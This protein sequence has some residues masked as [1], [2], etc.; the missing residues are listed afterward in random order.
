[1]DH[2]V[3]YLLLSTLLVLGRV[4]CDIIVVDTDAITE[5]AVVLNQDPIDNE[6][7][8]YDGA[9]LW[10]IGYSEQNHKNAVT[11]LQKQFQVSMW[12]LQMNN[13]SEHYVDLFIKSGVVKEAR[14]FL[15][16][17]RVPFNVVIQDIQNAINSENPSMDEEE[18]WENR[19]GMYD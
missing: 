14:S 3:K 17:I 10:R 12:N 16:N 18:H 2:L 9:Q 5:P 19:N 8:K 6:P 13:G 7:I 4:N 15:E 1:M 11:E